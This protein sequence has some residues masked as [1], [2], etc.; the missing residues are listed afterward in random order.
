M[1][2]HTV[3]LRALADPVL[4]LP[5]ARRYFSSKPSIHLEAAGVLVHVM[6]RGLSHNAPWLSGR[7][8]V[9]ASL[10]TARHF[11]RQ[12]LYSMRGPAV[13]LSPQ[14]RVLCA[15]PQDGGTKAWARTT[16]VAVGGCGPRICRVEGDASGPRDDPA[17]L[18]VPTGESF[19]CAMPPT[20]LDRMIELYDQSEMAYNEV[21]I[22][23]DSFAIEAVVDFGSS[24]GWQ[25]HKRLLD[26]FGLNDRQLPFLRFGFALKEVNKCPPGEPTASSCPL[27][28]SH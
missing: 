26:K 18:P 9:S 13:V 3:L 14:S 10:L 8:F 21:V 22:A 1:N 15:Y 24:D 5:P 4:T 17:D 23:A 16:K 6:E 2:A 11:G 25:V 28:V 12:G 19:P 20:M 7:T 27:F